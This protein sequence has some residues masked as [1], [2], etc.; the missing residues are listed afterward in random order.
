MRTMTML[1]RSRGVVALIGV[2]AILGACSKPQE[3]SAQGTPAS[4]SAPKA[5]TATSKAI[6]I[7]DSGST[8]TIGYRISIGADGDT[9]YVSGAGPGQATL[10]T[11]LYARLTS[12][13]AAAGPLSKLPAGSCMKPA[14]FGTAVKISLAGQTSPDLSCAGNDAATKLKDDIDAVV[15]FLKLEDV[16]RSQGK[17][18]PPQ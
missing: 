2:A 4:A 18:L 6:V 3:H 1:A 11:D 13:V 5:D 7:A 8:N 12:D 9:S 10:P 15:A 16:P 17:E 14:S